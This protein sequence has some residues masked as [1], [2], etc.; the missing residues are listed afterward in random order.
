MLLQ[1]TNATLRGILIVYLLCP[2]IRNYHL[3]ESYLSTMSEMD[4]AS[5]K[6]E[7]L[8]VV[9]HEELDER[10]SGKLMNSLKYWCKLAS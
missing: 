9:R 5:L 6:K 8:I 10:I 4:E 7:K 3:L 1:E 2:R